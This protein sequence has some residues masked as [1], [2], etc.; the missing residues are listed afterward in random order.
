VKE[1]LE[2]WQRLARSLGRMGEAERGEKLT[3]LTERLRLGR[4][5]QLQPARVRRL[6]AAPPA[7]RHGLLQPTKLLAHLAAGALDLDVLL[8]HVTVEGPLEK[9]QKL[10]ED[11]T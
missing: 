10:V 6:E 4:R 3:E 7:A 11:G 5:G 9:I 8:S 2:E 1:R